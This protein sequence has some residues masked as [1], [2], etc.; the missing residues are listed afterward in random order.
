MP[1]FPIYMDLY[2]YLLEKKNLRGKK[3]GK[4]NCQN[5][6]PTVTNYLFAI[7]FNNFSQEYLSINCEFMMTRE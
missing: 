1:S 5:S 6:N 4:I 3:G 7:C 2:T